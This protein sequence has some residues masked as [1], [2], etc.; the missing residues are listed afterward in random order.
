[1]QALKEFSLPVKGLKTGMHH[2]EFHIGR[3]F[4]S[5]FPDTTI[6]DGDFVV[7]VQ[8]EKRPD[9]LI[10]EL[11]ISGNLTQECDRCMNIIDIP[12]EGK[13][14]MIMKFSEEEYEDEDIVYISENEHEINIAKYLYEYI[15]LCIPIRKVRDCEAEN[16]KFCNKKVLEYII[17]AKSKEEEGNRLWDAF[18][19]IKL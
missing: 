8:L 10:F 6:N 16:Y 14:K 18:K 19:D 7:R 11:D 9:L 4:F 17:N 3:Y 2:F 15:H 1:M 13:H 5:H 12:V